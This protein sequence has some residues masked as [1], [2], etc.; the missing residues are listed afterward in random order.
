L[1]ALV[2]TFPI[3]H[4]RHSSNAEVPD[5]SPGHV[6]FAEWQRFK[7]FEARVLTPV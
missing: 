3:G 7:L 2:P 6:A 1:I 4:E 5:I